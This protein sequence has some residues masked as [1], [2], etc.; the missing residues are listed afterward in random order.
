LKDI[1]T[2]YPE[3]KAKAEASQFLGTPLKDLDRE[4]LLVVVSF[5]IDMVDHKDEMFESYKRMVRR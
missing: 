1:I 5:M 4:D 3:R 2:D